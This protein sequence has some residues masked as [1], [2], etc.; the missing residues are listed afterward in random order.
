VV[1]AQY[2]ES[3]DRFTWGVVAGAAALVLAGI[4]V[5]VALRRSPGPA[6]LA[7]PEGV[8]RAYME[9]ID[10]GKPEDAWPLLAAE[11]QRRV[12]R[13]EFVRQATQRFHA[14][15]EGR[16]SIDKVTVDGRTA[17]VELSR[18]YSGGGGLFGP[19]TYSNHY[20]ARL[21]QEGGAWRITVPPEDFF[22]RPG[23]PVVV[24]TATVAPSPTVA[25]APSSTPAPVA[26]TPSPVTGGTG[27]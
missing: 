12:P 17:R 9:A 22:F 27:R 2:D 20:N 25:P 11:Q 4:V 7:T 19:S 6:D 21:E 16:V 8:L 1:T 23:N 5:V 13:D 18:T 15:R 14:P 26:L 10:S 24:V 3:V